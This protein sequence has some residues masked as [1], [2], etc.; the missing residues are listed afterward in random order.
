MVGVR[1]FDGRFL[2]RDSAI[3]AYRRRQAEV[4]AAIAPER[5][6]VFDVAE[7][8]EPLCGFL[9]KPVP[10]TPFPRRNGREDF[11]A[12]LGGEPA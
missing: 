1:T 2:D 6:L 9:G 11:W 3:A 12:N 8:W 5:L 4:V 10:Q 7:G